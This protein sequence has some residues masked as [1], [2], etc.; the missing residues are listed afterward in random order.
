MTTVDWIT[1]LFCRI[2]DEM[3]AFPKHEQACLWPSK[4]VMLGADL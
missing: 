2:D 4:A 3:R 1:D